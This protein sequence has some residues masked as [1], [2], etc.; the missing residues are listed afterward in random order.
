MKKYENSVF[1][2]RKATLINKF[3]PLRSQIQN[4]VYNKLII[5]KARK[6]AL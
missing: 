4:T 5:N 3:I 6:E 2:G 1:S